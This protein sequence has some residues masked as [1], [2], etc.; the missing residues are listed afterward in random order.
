M[1]ASSLTVLGLLLAN[2]APAV[3]PT[4]TPL[5]QQPAKSAVGETVTSKPAIPTATSKPADQQKYGGVVTRALSRD[6]TSFDL[7]RESGAVRWQSAG[8]ASHLRYHGG[9]QSQGWDARDG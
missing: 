4:S 6:A 8:R 1:I 7:Q 2:C 9:G 3:T 5:V